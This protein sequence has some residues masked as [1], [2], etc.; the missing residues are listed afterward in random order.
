MKETEQN[1]V[2]SLILNRID[3]DNQCS[4]DLSYYE[5]IQN[6]RR[7]LS[8]ASLSCTDRQFVPATTYSFERLYSAVRWILRQ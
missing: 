4:D 1:A 3:I 7:K 6:K 8:S 5:Q 2:K